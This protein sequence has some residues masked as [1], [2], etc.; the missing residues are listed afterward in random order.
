MT[1]KTL[2]L[3]IAKQGA[4]SFH[5]L[6]IKGLNEKLIARIGRYETLNQSNHITC[7]LEDAEFTLENQ[8]SSPF[9]N[10][11]PEG[12]MPSL[13]GMIQSGMV[14]PTISTLVGATDGV[15]P[16]S[17]QNAGESVNQ[18]F[19]SVTK[20][21]I[22]EVATDKLSEWGNRIDS[23]KGRT[24]FT[25]INSEQIYVSSNA[26]RI[27]GTVVLVAWANAKKEVEEKLKSLQI[28]ATP[29]YLHNQSVLQSFA[30]N[31][32]DKLKA[33]FPSEIPPTVFLQYGG[34]QYAP[35][36]IESLSAPITAPMTAD[37]SRIAVKAQITFVNKRAWDKRDIERIYAGA[38]I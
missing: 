31:K 34:K 11:N 4:D 32:D 18:V 27:T 7:L 25:K 33:L 10:S 3:D 38:G 14:T 17:I 28:L 8:F 6:E 2:D 35:L 16:Q 23:L 37:G 24:S 29:A 26:V 13:M 21:D 9:E 1:G 36:F 30:T 22:K 12:R 5:L 15:V 20:I 19:E